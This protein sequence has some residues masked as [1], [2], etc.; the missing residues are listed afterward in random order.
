[1]GI[2]APETQG[3]DHIINPHGAQIPRR[4]QVNAL[5]PP[6]TYTVCMAGNDDKNQPKPAKASVTKNIRITSH[7]PHM[8]PIEWWDTCDIHKG[9]EET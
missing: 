6:D 1:M 8:N 5:S 2:T 3:L 9:T 4:E 7:E